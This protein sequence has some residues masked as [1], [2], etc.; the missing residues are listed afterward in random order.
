[1]YTQ[2]NS[3]EEFLRLQDYTT[4][5]KRHG[6]MVFISKLGAEILKKNTTWLLDGTFQTTPHPFEQVFTKL[7]IKI[8]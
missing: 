5:S 2:T 8:K 7:I 1:M 4:E 3:K 6:I